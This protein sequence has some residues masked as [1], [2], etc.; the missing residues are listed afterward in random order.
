[1]PFSAPP[2]NLLHTLHRQADPS[3]IF[4][5]AGA[6]SP[7]TSPF[8]SISEQLLLLSP[9]YGS[10]FV[11]A[12]EVAPWLPTYSYRRRYPIADVLLSLVLLAP[13]LLVTAFHQTFQVVSPVSSRLTR[14]KFLIREH[15]IKYET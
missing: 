4:L 13:H 2:S 15:K 3:P 10:L 5:L 6:V 8:P 11:A 12:G 1:M 14:M 7:M 9:T